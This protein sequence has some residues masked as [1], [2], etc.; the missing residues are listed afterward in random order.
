MLMAQKASL[1]LRVGNIS[2]LFVR[3]EVLTA[4]YIKSTVIVHS[5]VEIYRCFEGTYCLHVHFEIGTHER[6]ICKYRVCKET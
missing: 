6:H 1:Y 3:F 4:L 2:V 5:V